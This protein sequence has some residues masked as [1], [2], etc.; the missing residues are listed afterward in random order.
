MDT[1]KWPLLAQILIGLGIISSLVNIYEGLLLK[2]LLGIVV[3]II[4]LLI[5]WYVYKFKKWAL[6]VLNILLSLSIAMAL[7]SI[8]KIPKLILFVA[9]IYPAS[10]LLYFNST[11]IRELFRK[12][13]TNSTP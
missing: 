9:I 8:G 12:T 11:K 10:L 13:E 3:G 7:V 4:G 2:N 5:Y 6:I 1:K